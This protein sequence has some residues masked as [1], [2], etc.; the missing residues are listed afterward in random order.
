MRLSPEDVTLFYKLYPHLLLFANQRMQLEDAETVD[1]VMYLPAENR[2]AIREALFDNSDLIEDFAEANP[3]KFNQQELDIVL[4]WKNF[5]KGRF[6]LFRQLKSYAI[7]LPFKE[8]TKAYGVLAIADSFTELVPFIPIIVDTVL[9]PFK[10]KIVYDGLL[11]SQ[12]IYFG[13]GIKRSLNDTYNEAK[14]KYGIIT[15]LTQ[16]AEPVKAT[17]DIDQLKYY[18]RSERNREYYWDDI[19]KLVRKS[20]Q[21]RTVYYQEIGKYYAKQYGRKLRELG[22]EGGWF[23]ILESVIIGSGKTKKE[24][25]TNIEEI[26]SKKKMNHV[27]LFQLR[28]KK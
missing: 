9:L 11:S 2:L 22:I 12:N 3:E 24:A 26:V 4:S 10:G 23:G 19:Q 27:Y 8:T 16:A 28:A 15:S 14:A 6:Y 25:F 7:F 18:L 5:L 17:S 20:E 1:E 13:G 21:N